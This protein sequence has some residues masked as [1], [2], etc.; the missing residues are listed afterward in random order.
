MAGVSPKEGDTLT[1]AVLVQDNY[2]RKASEVLSR[3]EVLA[4]G[5][6]E[7]RDYDMLDLE[8]DDTYGTEV[9]S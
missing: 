8:Q 5:A 6:L 3:Y 9:W 1:F 7:Y 2:G 4:G